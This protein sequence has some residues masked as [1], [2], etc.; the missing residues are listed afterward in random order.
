MYEKLA[1]ELYAAVIDEA[2]QNGLRVTAHIFN[3]ADAKALLRA[4]LDA[5]AH[6]TAIPTSTTRSCAVP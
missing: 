4:G 2:H 1:P 3:L 6:G 5:F